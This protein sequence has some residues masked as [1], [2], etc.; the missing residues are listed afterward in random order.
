MCIYI[1]TFKKDFASENYLY[2][3][4]HVVVQSCPIH[5]TLKCVLKNRD[6]TSVRASET[7]EDITIQYMFS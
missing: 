5:N 6:T 7:E 4:H 1:Y 3:S 2:L